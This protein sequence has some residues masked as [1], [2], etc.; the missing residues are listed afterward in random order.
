MIVVFLGIV[1]L[2]IMNVTVTIL[3]VK[4]ILKWMENKANN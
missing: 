3:A 4:F 1:L 2:F